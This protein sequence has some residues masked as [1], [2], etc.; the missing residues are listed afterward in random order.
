MGA[1]GRV[2][3]RRTWV[4]PKPTPL[5]ASVYAGLQTE[6]SRHQAVVA[7][8][9]GSAAAM[10]RPYVGTSVGAGHDLCLRARGA[11]T[12][13]DR[14]PRAAAGAGEGGDDDIID[15]GGGAGEMGRS[16]C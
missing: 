4:T 11:I 16:R 1:L 7:L 3:G 14:W 2:L 6:T 12:K 9:P 15:D 10:S 5:A 8:P 13:E